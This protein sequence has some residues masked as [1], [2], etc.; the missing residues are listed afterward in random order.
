MTQLTEKSLEDAIV[1][2]AKLGVKSRPDFVTSGQL[3]EIENVLANT[4][5]FVSAA[6]KDVSGVLM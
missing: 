5:D 4:D 1:K 6:F 2:M 3:D